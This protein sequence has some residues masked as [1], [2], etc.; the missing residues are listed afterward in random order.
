MDTALDKTKAGGVVAMIV[1]TGL[2]VGR[3][4]GEA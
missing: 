2:M 1:P 4:A 3:L